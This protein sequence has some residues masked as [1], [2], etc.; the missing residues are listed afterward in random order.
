MSWGRPPS[1]SLLSR[2]PAPGGVRPARLA[3]RIPSP[4]GPQKVAVD[5]RL[6]LAAVGLR[7]IWRRLLQRRAGIRVGRAAWD[8]VAQLVG[9]APERDRSDCGARSREPG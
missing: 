7:K 6:A 9:S 3:S 1:M 4:S 8:V 2:R 5:F